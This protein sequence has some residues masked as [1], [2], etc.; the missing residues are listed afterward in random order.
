[1]SVR[2]QA[3]EG[4]LSRVLFRALERTR[5]R[6]IEGALEETVESK[7]VLENEIER[8]HKWAIDIAQKKYHCRDH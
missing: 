1:M 5:E 4:A 6:V 8:E 7:R 3:L 2:E